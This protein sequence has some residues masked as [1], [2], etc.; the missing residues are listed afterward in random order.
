M[1]SLTLS[2]IAA[3]AGAKLESG[4]GN[5]SVAKVSTDSRTLKRG[6]F[7]VALRGENFDGHDFVEA[8]A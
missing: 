3:L 1:N 6:E 2:Q 4:N 5:I 8:A 7:F